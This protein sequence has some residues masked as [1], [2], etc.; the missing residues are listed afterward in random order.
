[1]CAKSKPDLDAA[2]AL[3]TPEDSR[4]LYAAWAETY[5]AGF[6]RASDYVLPKKVAEHFVDAG[7]GGTVLDIGAGTGL[8]GQALTA[9]GVTLVDGTDISPEMLEVAQ[10][11]RVYSSLFAADVTRGLPVSDGHYDGVVSSGTF[12]NGHVGPDAL[13]ELL[14]VTR[15]GGLLALSI[16]GAHFETC[17]FAQKLD[18]LAGQIV[19]LRL[20]EIRFYGAHATGAHK[21]DTGYVALFRKR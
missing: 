10:K 14:R 18:A 1:M 9:L 19:D 4:R 8:C 17:G 11:K 7:G 16:N 3:K 5:D 13:D 21:D 2:Y 6:A 15:A 20:P 12:T